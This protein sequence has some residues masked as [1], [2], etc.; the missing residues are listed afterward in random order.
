MQ[1]GHEADRLNLLV[2]DDDRSELALLG[3]AIEKSQHNI[4]LQTAPDGQ[5][6]IDYLLGR[7]V[8]ADRALHPL[9]ELI[10]LDLDMPLSGGFEFLDWRMGT[11]AFS[12]LPIAVMSGWAYAGAIRAAISL[13]ANAS[14]KKPL[15]NDDEWGWVVEQIWNIRTAWQFPTAPTGI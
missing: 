13:G 3:L 8:F 1:P 12:S 14:I 6:A 4:W 7:E 9:P 11:P 5:R 10:V 2:I 15:S